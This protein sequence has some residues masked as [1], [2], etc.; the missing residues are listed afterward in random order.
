MMRNNL[1]WCHLQKPEIKKSE[2][3]TENSVMLP[4]YDNFPKSPHCRKLRPNLQQLISEL[5]Y[6]YSNA[7]M[8]FTKEINVL[9]PPPKFWSGKSFLDSSY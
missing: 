6:Q 2:N 4:K 8:S 3:F 1:I 7:F 9:T 5:F